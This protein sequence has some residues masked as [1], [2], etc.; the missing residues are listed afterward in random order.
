MVAAAFTVLQWG[1]YRARFSAGRRL[2]ALYFGQVMLLG[3]LVLLRQPW[4]VAGAALLLAP[5]SWWLA[6]HGEAEAALARSL[7]W[8]WASMLAVAVIVR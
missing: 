4:A 7:P 3:T 6:R 5:P 8:W 2:V 1:F